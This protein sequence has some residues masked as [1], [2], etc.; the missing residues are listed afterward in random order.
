MSLTT[1]AARRDLAFHLHP[2]TNLRQLQ[3]DGPLVITRGEG[4]YVY[5]D[6]GRRYLE[7]MSG[8]WCASL[9][10]SE[11]RLAE[12]AYRQM[13]ELPF[14]HSF[15][16]KVPAISAELAERLI[17]IAPAGMGRVLF[18]NSGS[19]ANDTAIKLAWYVNN[20][21]GRPKKK[22]IIA[23]RRAYH[24]VTIASGSLT[25]LAFA[26]TDFDLPIDRIL[27]TDAADYYR[28]AQAGESEEAFAARLADNLERLILREGPDTVAAF[29]A[30][31]VMGAG[32][33]LVPPATYF[34]RIQPILRKYDIL[35]VADEVI[36]GFGRTG[37]MFGTQTFGLKPDII[38]VA[39]ALSA[40][41][42]P[43]SANLVS[44]A[45]Y[46]V[47]LAQSDKLGIFGHGYTYS[48]HP[49]PAAVALE[50]LKIYEERD[51]LSHVRLVGA[52]MQAGLRSHADHPLIGDARGVGLIGALEIVRDKNTRASFDPKAGVGAFLVRRAQHHGVILRNMPGDI[53]A[54]CPP[55]IVTEREIDEMF[56][57]FGKA[58]VDTSNMVRES[59]LA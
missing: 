13:L 50:T 16:G 10:F 54:F 17:G 8:L 7:G 23:R 36:C 27:H 12:A 28:G 5:D 45:L 26:H 58:L 47:L 41:Y 44:N 9:G 24:G 32:G 37:Q 4:V 35:F 49:V 42:V 11:R 33:V 53:V 39:K 34:D 30:E 38:T 52:Y 14:Y 48:S 56:A 59:G 22:K 2:S 6:E 3:T 18:A 29:F 46:D 43:I 25:G 20:A 31:P 1:S 51:I 55:L 15:A 57:G 19:E 21:L 40:G